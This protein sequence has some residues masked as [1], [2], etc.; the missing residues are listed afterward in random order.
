[1][2]GGE[3]GDW[4]RV[5]GRLQSARQRIVD[6]VA[7][8]DPGHAAAVVRDYHQQAVQRVMAMRKG[9]ETERSEALT[10]ALAAWLRGERRT[11]R[12][13][14]QAAYRTTV[15]GPGPRTPKRP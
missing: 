4:G 8:R 11:R 1:M 10:E 13:D 14:R 5:A 3:G 2:S 12:P 7:R 6:A 9:D 15:T